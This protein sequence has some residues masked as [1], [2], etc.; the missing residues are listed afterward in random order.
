MYF[1]AFFD[2]Q[3]LG[4]V[5]LMMTM[6]LPASPAKCHPIKRHGLFHSLFLW[7]LEASKM[8]CIRFMHVSVH[9]TPS[10]FAVYDS[11]K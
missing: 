3:S 8:H 6:T 5:L 9:L 2:N 11:E 1:Y 4:M 10:S 7:R